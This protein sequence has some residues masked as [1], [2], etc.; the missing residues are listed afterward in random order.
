MNSVTRASQLHVGVSAAAL[1][2]VLFATSAFA[3]TAAPETTA[4]AAEP[5]STDSTEADPEVVVVTAER[6]VQSLQDYAGT[7]ITIT[8]DDLRATGLQNFNDL[9]GRVPGLSVSNNQGS[10]EVYIRGVGSSN[11]TELGDPAAA[12]HFNGVYVPRP[13]G[14]G[15]AFFDIQRVEVNIGPQGTLRGRNATAGSV[16]VLPWKPGLGILNGSAE[17]SAGNYGEF[18]AEG[19]INVP[20][21]ENSAFRLAAYF[22]Q[23]DSYLTNVT[24][25]SAEL[26]LSVPTAQSEGVGV[27][28]AADDLGLRASYLMELSD[29]WTVTLTG[30]Y[31]SQQGTGYTGINFANPL[32]NGIDPASIDEP[33]KVFGRAFT[34][35][36][37]TVHWG[38]KLHIEYD[39]DLFNAEF[40]SSQRDLVYDYEFVTPAGPAYPGALANL[41]P[42]AGTFD[43]FSRVRFIT[44]SESTVNELR[45]FSDAN[46][47]LIWAA[48]VFHFTEAQRTFLGTTGDRNPFFTGVEFNQTTDTQSLSYYGD[49]TFKVTDDI[50]L[51]LGARNTSDEKERFGVN[52]RYQFILGGGNFSCC[53]GTGHGTEG[54][55]FAGLD[56]TLFNP[57]TNGNGALSDQEVLGFFFNGVKQFGARDGLDNIFA[58][59]IVAGDAPAA[60][61][62][63]CSTFTFT[64]QCFNTFVPALDGRLSFGVLG[65][66]S[67]ALQNGRLDNSFSDW[68]VRGELDLSDDNLLYA[69]VAT[70]NKSGGFNDNIPGTEGLG[71]FSAASSAPA[72]FDVDTLAPTYGPETLTLYE[73]GSKNEFRINGQRATLNLSAFYYDYSNMQLT[74]LLSTAQIL[75]AEGITL[76]PAQQAQLGG[77]IVS[78]TFNAANAEIYGAQIEGSMR[79]ANGIGL[80]GTLLWLP[81]A[82]VVDSQEIQDARFQADVDAA[83]SVNRSIEGNRLVRTPEIQFNGSISQSWTFDAGTLDGV[84]SVGYRSDQRMTIFNGRDYA[85][86]NNPAKRLD[87]N[88]EAFVTVDAGIGFSPRQAFQ[89]RF[90]AYGANLTEVQQPQAIIIT[91]FDNTR[92]FNRPR[93]FG[94]RIRYNF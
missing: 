62:P 51:T 28:E 86:P 17:F 93:T 65:G 2:A 80:K 13:A 72:A 37:D 3:Q 75:N 61:H 4:Q 31:L 42:F 45:L 22:L 39:G 41:Q 46:Q 23:R 38:A 16:D 9:D 84:L 63:L 34:P 20:V 52:A 40:I 59:G 90:E 77:N 91:Q 94:A 48:G 81:E 50:R 76:T 26:G 83:N 10:L 70:G 5:V 64:G 32:G 7:A 57:D 71:S 11:N 56:R 79:F 78:Y 73:I 15:A 60:Q 33:R 36:E 18:S 25:T 69:L 27:A 21:T 19:V 43:N 24:P 66:N 67:I 14:F 68:R 82:R 49:A 8:G 44:D 85:N 74:T 1:C 58:N 47:R 30:D 6:R 92:F 55:E 87:D 54:F 29:Q 89:W 88:V 53:F 35:Q 12:T